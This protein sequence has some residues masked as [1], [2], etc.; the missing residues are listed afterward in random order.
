MTD[1]LSERVKARLNIWWAHMFTKE[2]SLKVFFFTP[3]RRVYLL[4]CHAGVHDNWQLCLTGVNTFHHFGVCC[5]HAFFHQ[6]VSINKDKYTPR[7]NTAS[8]H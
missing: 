4:F 3:H 1:M 2:L 6:N 5:I 7:V 8:K